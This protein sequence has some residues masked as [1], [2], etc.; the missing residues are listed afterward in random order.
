[1]VKMTITIL[2]TLLLYF[3]KSRIPTI[4]LLFARCVV[5]WTL[6][7]CPKKA[8]IDLCNRVEIDV[9]NLKHSSPPQPVDGS[10]YI[11][12]FQRIHNIQNCSWEVPHLLCTQY[13]HENCVTFQII[14][15]VKLICERNNVKRN[16]SYGLRCV[17]IYLC[18]SFLIRF[19]VEL[20]PRKTWWLE[21]TGDVSGF[22]K[23]H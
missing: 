2:A 15:C 1:M 19:C 3:D 6:R 14:Y 17:F 13:L 22:I 4:I 21:L 20:Q 5:F 10:Q 23:Q 7:W 8:S 16:I 12:L 11:E 18:D 9:T